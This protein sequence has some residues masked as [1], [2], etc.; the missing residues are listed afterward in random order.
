MKRSQS[1]DYYDC[2]ELLTPAERRFRNTIREWVDRIYAPRASAWFE[3]GIFPA[4]LIPDMARLGL[5]GIKLGDY[6]GPGL[7]SLCYGLACQELERG[8]SGLRSFVS[9]MN[10]LVIYPILTFG[11][12]EQRDRWLPAMVRGEKVGCFGLTEPEAGSDPGSMKTVATRTGDGY[13][14]NG[15]KMWIT[16]GEIAH[17]AVIWARSEEGIKG[18]LVEKDTPGFTARPVQGKLSMRASVTS[19]LILDNVVVPDASLLPGAHGLKSVLMCLNQARFGVAWGALG[20]AVACYEAAL[21]HAKKRI[22]FGKPLAARQLIQ[23]K[24]VSMVSEI[25]KGQLLCLRLA[26]LMDRGRAR[27]GQV[28]MAKM[29]NVATALKIART[30]RDILGA[31][32]I[33][34]QYPVIRHMLNLESVYTYEG[35]HTVHT[36]IIGRDITGHNA[37]VGG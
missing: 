14:I 7:N 2:E 29:N 30:A 1:V 23:D 25:T 13:R 35:T 16:N 9:V 12:E 8:D 11:S 21:D 19:A 27:P 33:G 28:S 34:L 17:V 26:K 15:R 37:L 36:L 31:R 6:G 24:L 20:A 22:Q 32:G 4:D 5:L 10:S 3:A 18:F